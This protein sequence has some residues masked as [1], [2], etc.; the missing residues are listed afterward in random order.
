MIKKKGESVTVEHQGGKGIKSRDERKAGRGV[1]KGIISGKG[2]KGKKKKKR[3]V[4]ER[5]G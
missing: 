3:M 1:A 4:K 2:G 5:S